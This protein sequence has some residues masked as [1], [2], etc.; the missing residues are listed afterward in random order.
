M[1]QLIDACEVYVDTN[2]E[3]AT[4]CVMLIGKTMEGEPIQYLLRDVEHEV[5]LAIS[6]RFPMDHAIR[7]RN[8][9]N[10]MLLRKQ[11]PCKVYGTDACTCIEK[12]WNYGGEQFVLSNE[13]CLQ[14]RLTDSVAIVDVQKIRSRGFTGYEPNDRPFLKFRL[15]R[16]YYA[17]N[18]AAKFMLK[19]CEKDSL[20]ASLRGV[21][22]LTNRATESFL[23]TTGAGGF[24]WFN[25]ADGKIIK[26]QPDDI[27]VIPL[28]VLVF[29]IETLSETGET[30]AERG[31]PVGMITLKTL[32]Y[33]EGAKVTEAEFHS[34]CY[35]GNVTGDVLC[36]VKRPEKW[37]VY[38]YGTELEMLNA[39]HSFFMNYDP[40]MVGG[41]NS[42]SF[43]MPYVLTRLQMLGCSNWNDW[44]RL[45]PK[46]PIRY[47]RKTTKSAQ[48][49]AQKRTTIQCFGR[50][51]IDAFYVVKDDN[52]LKFEGY[53]LAEVTVGLKIKKAKGD[54]PYEKIFE[55]FHGTKEQRG[56]LLLYNLI[57]VDITADIIDVRKM[58][59]MIVNSSRTYHVLPRDLLDRGL[60]YDIPHMVTERSYGRYL[61]PA[62]VYPEID[63]AKEQ[64]GKKKKKKKK[65]RS[66]PLPPASVLEVP[67]EMKLRAGRIKGG[68]VKKLKRPVMYR[69]PVAVFDFNSLYPSVIRAHNICHTTFIR[70][71]EY[72]ESIGLT[73]E[74]YFTAPNG[75]M[76]VCQ[77]ILMGVI[78]LLMTSLMTKRER[79]KEDMKKEKD[80]AL[81]AAFD[82][83]QNAVKTAANSTYGQFS[84][85]A[86]VLA[87]YM[88]GAAVTSYS[89]KYIKATEKYIKTEKEVTKFDIHPLYG[90][91]DSTMN[92]FHAFLK[93]ET[94]SQ[95]QLDQVRREFGKVQKLINESSGIMRPPM[96][97]G[98]DSLNI[99]GLFLKKKSYALAKIS[100]KE[101]DPADIEL[102]VKGLQFI[103]RDTNRY[104]RN[105]GHEFLQM[106]MIRN[107]SP[108]TMFEFIR[109]KIEDILAGNVERDLL[110]MSAVLS[111][112]LEEYGRVEEEEDDE[113]VEQENDDDEQEEEE[114]QAAEV[115]VGS[116]HV[117]AA[118]QMVAAGMTVLPGDRIKY[119]FRQPPANWSGKMGEIV[120][121]AKLIPTTEKQEKADKKLP[122]TKL[123]L[124]KYAERFV[125]PFQTVCKVLFGKRATEELLNLQFY[126]KQSLGF[127]S[128][129][130]HNRD[131]Q[132]GWEEESSATSE[133][134]EEE[135]EEDEEKVIVKKEKKT[136]R[137]KPVAGKAS[138]FSL[139][140]F[141]TKKAKVGL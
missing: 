52:T 134:E 64:D 25:E 24:M 44:S 28:K 42:N 99:R 22:E 118:R 54:V 16:S 77:H 110:M 138:T 79:V 120:I 47:L 41:Y 125:A 65:E 3:R 92:G 83:I 93:I 17:T 56:E 67:A 8:E 4:Q 101:G 87:L 30:F 35:C 34:F 27:L 29:D 95:E 58:I 49:G 113:S 126:S 108:Q 80:P 139:E 19:Y 72:A 104:T 10:A 115:Q 130:Q 129:I 105:C 21:F 132:N 100:M 71:K 26:E 96:K 97:V 20:P 84:M 18:G 123:Y 15:S 81:K 62:P 121:A 70:S 69:A 75:A 111:K 39:F 74:D 13:A 135:E 116:M 94:L 102:Q 43:D 109:S 128:L 61:R 86:S 68:Y 2:G 60:S 133:S 38:I 55:Y 89:R 141:F 40:D 50:I 122:K 90:D 45:G 11:S 36:P 48:K 82:A 23:N 66:G 1:F 31:H 131:F 85:K 136:K 73:P 46:Y 12:P 76:F 9:L 14:D 119:F 114:E 37:Q 107:E 57:D 51:F 98:M 140:R 63:W 33:R 59:G 91:T 53:T 5:F 124:L 112:P 127:A 6:E 32:T 137:P 78:P 106:V 103:K 117:I 88:A 7:L